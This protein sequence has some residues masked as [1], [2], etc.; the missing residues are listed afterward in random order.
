MNVRC[1]SIAEEE[2]AQAI[3]YCESKE[4][5]L[6]LRFYVEYLSALKR[7]IPPRHI[8]CSSNIKPRFE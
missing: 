5:G 7:L 1:L 2:L 6:G 8:H 4:V 3:E